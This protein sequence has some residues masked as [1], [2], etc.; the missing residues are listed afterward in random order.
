MEIH[1]KSEHPM[2]VEGEQFSVD[3][4]TCDDE[5]LVNLGFYNYDTNSWSFHSDTVYDYTDVDFAWVY[6]PIKDMLKS[7]INQ[8][9][10]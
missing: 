1:N 9:N 4:I 7:L 6:P 2:Q 10:N 5:G 3:V 8:K